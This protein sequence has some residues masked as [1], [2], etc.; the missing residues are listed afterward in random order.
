[1]ISLPNFTH[2]D[3]RG[4]I[5]IENLDVKSKSRLREPFLDDCLSIKQFSVKSKEMASLSLHDSVIC[6]LLSSIWC[7]SKLTSFN[8]SNCHDFFRCK[9]CNDINLGG[10]LANI[11]NLSMLT[12]LGLG[13]CRNLVSQPEL[14]STLSELYLDHCR[15][16][17]SLLELPPSLERVIGLLNSTTCVH[18]WF[19]CPPRFVSIFYHT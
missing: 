2:L 6:P 16:L 17:V 9:Q 19:A 12:W 7:N 10:F 3:L 13:D 1:M 18:S 15:K 4:C 8:L 11:K 5:E 14:P